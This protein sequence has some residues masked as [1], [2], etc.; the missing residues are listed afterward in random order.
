M[1]LR[2]TCAVVTHTMRISNSSKLVSLMTE[3]YGLVKVMAKGARR[4]KS[5]YGAA[6]EPVSLIDCIYYHRETRDIQTLSNTEIIESYLRIKSDITLLAIASCMIEIAHTYT[7][8]ENPSKETFTLLVQSL[9]GLK[10]C[11]VTDADKHLWRFLLLFLT[12]SGYHP[13]LDRCMVCGKKPRGESVFLSCVDGG[14]L[15]SCTDPGERYGLRVNPGTLM[16]INDLMTSKIED[17]ARLKIGQAQ[18]S[19][20]E[21]VT[22]QFL[23]Y[24]SGSSRT[25]RSLAF[26]RKLE[27][28]RKRKC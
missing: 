22:L 19:E 14:I 15:C 26:L 18:R 23:S 1:G 10:S 13:S 9:Y 17:L 16:I 25:L 6:L 2:S 4:P 27:A 21:H 24:H 12:V 5:K 20:V 8:P 11:A 7:A 28:D 3:R